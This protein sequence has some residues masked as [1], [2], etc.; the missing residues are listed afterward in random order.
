MARSVEV[1]CNGCVTC[2][3]AKHIPRK[4]SD[5]GN[6]NWTRNP[7][8]GDGNGHRY[9]AMD[10]LPRRWVQIF[11]PHGRF[12]HQICRGTTTTGSGGSILAAFQQGWVYRGHG[13]PYI[14][15]SDRGANIDGQAF[16]EFCAKAGIDKRSAT[17]Y[18]P[19]C[20]GMAERN[21]G[22]VK[23]VIRCLQLDRQLAKG[24]WPGLLTE[25][26]FHINSMENTTT[27]ISPHLL[28]LGSDP[29]SPLDA[30]C[31]HIQEGER[32]SHGEYLGALRRK[33]SELRRIAQENISK[34]LGKARARYNE[35]KR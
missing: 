18:H 24:S 2:Q 14:V 30:W 10:G 9:T 7:G 3:K 21:V 31:T 28:H 8:G 16:R 13:M 15:L 5:E 22:L 26:S 6:E 34:N 4:S 33:R 27:R 1:F 11:P 17:P 23:Q 25:V 35:D 12:V 20:D 29:R 32:N 19:Q